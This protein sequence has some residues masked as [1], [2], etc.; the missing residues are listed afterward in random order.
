MPKIRHIATG[1]Y[2]GDMKNE[3]TND[4]IIDHRPGY[5]GRI[6]HISTGFE[7]GVEFSL[8]EAYQYINARP[9]FE[10]I[11]PHGEWWEGKFV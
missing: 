11:A 4:I 7:R 10:I 9:G 3:D 2:V 5:G 6:D 1:R 8:D